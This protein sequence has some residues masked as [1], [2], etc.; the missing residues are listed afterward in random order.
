GVECVHAARRTACVHSPVQRPLAK[1]ARALGNSIRL[2][3]R[4]PHLSSWAT[5]LPRLEHRNGRGEKSPARLGTM[6]TRLSVGD[7]AP[8]FTLPTDQGTFSLADHRGSNV[9]VYFYPAAMTQ[10]CTTQA[11]DFQEHLSS[12]TSAGYVVVGISPDSVDT[13]AEF[14]ALEGLN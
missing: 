5:L 11:C 3:H 4:K 6:T 8:D 1:G 9:I 12:L 10:G 14:R 13:L 2:L 7:L